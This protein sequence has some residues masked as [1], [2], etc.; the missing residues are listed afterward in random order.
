MHGALLLP[1]LLQVAV[2]ANRS[3]DLIA[4]LEEASA[5][6]EKLLEKSAAT[7]AEKVTERIDGWAFKIPTFKAERLRRGVREML[8]NKKAGS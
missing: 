3:L 7:I 6:A 2:S 4:R 1:L 8:V 5:K